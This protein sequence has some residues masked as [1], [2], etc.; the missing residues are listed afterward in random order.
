MNI[1]RIRLQGFKS[2]ADILMEDI[3][4]FTVFAGANG[5][6]KSNFVDGL[7]F[8]SLVV[9]IGAKAAVDHYG[10][11]E[12]IHCFRLE[13]TDSKNCSFELKINLKNKDYDYKIQLSA[14]NKEPKI[15]E[16]LIVDGETFYDSINDSAEFKNFVFIIG[17]VDHP[18]PPDMSILNI[19]QFMPISQFIK[20]M[21]VFRF[22]P[23]I[24]KKPYKRKA[25]FPY[26]DWDGENLATILE[27]LLKKDEYKYQIIE[28]LELIVPSMKNIATTN[29]K[30]DDST[31]MLFEEFGSNRKLPSHLIS[32]G[33]AYVLCII[34]AIL[35]RQELGLTIIEEPENGIH[36]KAI[37]ELV[38][39]M[40][41]Q[42]SSNHPIFITSH[43][44]AVIR[45]IRVDELWLV[46]KIDG[47]TQLKNA[48]KS[49]IDFGNL[50]LD[51]AWLMNF[52]DGGLPW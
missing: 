22:D 9:A 28:W 46:N 11:Y 31:V 15:T 27:K 1:E 50:N 45:S 12:D 47:K 41:D 44:E 36:S 39:L 14:L 38:S 13:K 7:E 16:R 42:A 40:R 18:V 34:A 5:S 23:S 52:F 48:K 43:A 25:N 29:H 17:N 30:L 21:R 32:D 2:A 49:S 35:S 4:S 26:L 51:K 10:G 19:L 24:S 3:S 8:F 6:G 37:A 20:N 33:T